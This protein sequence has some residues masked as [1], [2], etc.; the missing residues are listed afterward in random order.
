MIRVGG[1]L[2]R[3]VAGVGGEE[4]AWEVGAGLPTPVL[5]RRTAKAGLGGVHRLIG[6]PGTVGGGVFMNAGAHGQDFSQVVRAVDL[7]QADGTLRHVPAGEIA[8]RYRG[9]GLDG[10][11]IVAATIELIPGDPE[12]L[13]KEIR[14]HLRWRQA[15]TPFNEA[16]CGSVFRNPA[17]ATPSG[18]DGGAGAEGAEL[19][20]AGQLI[21]A[22]GLKGF[23]I[24]GAQVSPKHANYIVNTGEATAKD[25]LAV[26]DAVRER[27]SKE[28]GVELELEV[29]IIG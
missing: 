5:A 8:W 7:L 24:G 23:R 1:G 14:Q 26:I 15:G 22:A 18:A 17:A 21:D 4:A 12:Q 29:R 27:V 9:A 19:R 10:T 28:F 25:V 11:V 13:L 16:C 2:D 6:V 20:T 3:A